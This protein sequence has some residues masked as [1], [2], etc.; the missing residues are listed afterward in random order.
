MGNCLSCSPTADVEDEIVSNSTFSLLSLA[1]RGAPE[2]FTEIY[3]SHWRQVYLLCLR[4]TGNA[5]EAEDLSQDA[6]IQ[7]LLSLD[8]F[9]GR[10]TFATWLHRVVVNTVMMQ[11]R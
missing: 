11:R 10:S 9:Q 1:K 4:M 6:F 5:M 2:A 8:T 3:K 7:V